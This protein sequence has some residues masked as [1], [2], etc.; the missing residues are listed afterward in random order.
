MI[1]RANGLNWP[2]EAGGHLIFF[3]PDIPLFSILA[4]RP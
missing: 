1:Y 4:S 3:P 2:T